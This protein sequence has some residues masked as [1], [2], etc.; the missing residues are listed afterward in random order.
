MWTGDHVRHSQPFLFLNFLEL[1]ET[2]K[3]ADAVLVA[4]A[5]KELG[6]PDQFGRRR[7]DR[8]YRSSMKEGTRRLTGTRSGHRRTISRISNAPFSLHP[9]SSPRTQPSVISISAISI[10]SRATASC[11]R[12]QIPTLL[13]RLTGNTPR[14]YPLFSSLVY[15]VA[16]R[17]TMTRSRRLS[18]P[19]FRRTLSRTE[20]GNNLFSHSGATP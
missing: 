9:R 11:R 5:H 8:Y 16:Y 12:R 3:S 18:F 7:T 14:S 19:S 10:S 17:T 15:Q 4:A 2:D 13:T 20:G 6:F 1:I